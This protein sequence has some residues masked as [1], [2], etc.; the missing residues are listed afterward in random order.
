VTTFGINIGEK[1]LINQV[2]EFSFII[3]LRDQSFT[4]NSDF[5]LKVLFIDA[6]SN[7]LIYPNTSPYFLMN[8]LNPLAIP[9]LTDNSILRWVY[10]FSKAKDAENN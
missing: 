3:T 9:C 8:P 2:A 6:G 4:S 5:K 7:Q 10:S 1:A